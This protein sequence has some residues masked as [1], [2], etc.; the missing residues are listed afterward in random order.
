MPR[1]E[2]WKFPLLL[3][4]VGAHAWM[5]WQLAHF[6]PTQVRTPT[7]PRPTSTEP[8]L[9]MLLDFSV[10]PPAPAAARGP[11]RTPPRRKTRTATVG[12]TGPVAAH[13]SSDTGSTDTSTRLDLQFRQ[14]PQAGLGGPDPLRHRPTLEYQSTRYD[15]AWISDGNLTHVVARKSVVAGVLLSVMGALRK[16]CT[17]REREQYDAACVPASYRHP[18]PGQAR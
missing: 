6:R 16:D 13:G 5:G 18:A 4:V 11:A 8:E 15:K 12:E 10:R 9:L 17:E 3:L 14:A 1:H 2:S 7:A